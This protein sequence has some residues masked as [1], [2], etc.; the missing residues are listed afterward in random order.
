MEKIR[1]VLKWLDSHQGLAT[2]GQG[3]FTLAAGILAIVAA[4]IAY[5]GIKEQIA[6]TER[7]H[8]KAGEDALRSLAAAIWAE[9]SDSRLRIAYMQREARWHKANVVERKAG[10][11][12]APE[13]VHDWRINSEIYL[14]NLQAI[15][16]LPS[17]AVWG[18]VRV[19][20][21]IE[22]KNQEIVSA[23]ACQN[24][25]DR[26]D[27]MRKAYD[28][29]AALAEG[30]EV[31][32]ERLSTYAKIDAFVIAAQKNKVEELNKSTARN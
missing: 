17:F 8:E 10:S 24:S 16:K 28:D 2:W 4:R 22:S 5:N 15:G 25:Q 29:T 20:K 3:V 6:S 1:C 23:L 27:E 21:A 12:P 30:I 7:L 14:S 32:L 13:P 9:L 26:H 11:L 18:M 31:V 19:Y